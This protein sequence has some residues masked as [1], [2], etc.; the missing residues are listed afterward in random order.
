MHLIA[1]SGPVPTPP[2]EPT[3]L[4]SSFNSCC[5]FLFNIWDQPADE[6]SLFLVGAPCTLES[7]AKRGQRRG[8]SAC[9]YICCLFCLLR[10]P[11]IHR[12][13]ILYFACIMSVYMWLDLLHILYTCSTYYALYSLYALLCKYAVY[14]IHS[15]TYPIFETLKIDKLKYCPFVIY[16]YL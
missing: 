16:N 15:I 7:V 6:R 3:R 14:I 4:P 12:T 9:T 13:Y 10:S 2:G 11:H 8:A 5:M 1:I